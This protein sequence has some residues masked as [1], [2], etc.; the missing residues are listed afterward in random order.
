MRLKRATTLRDFRRRRRFGDE[1]ADD[2]GA[3]RR[4][5][6]RKQRRRRPQGRRPQHAR[7]KRRWSD[8][9]PLGEN[10]RIQAKDGYRGAYVEIRPGLYVVAELRTEGLEDDFGRKVRP[11]DVASEIFRVS[12]QA[13]NTFMPRR[14]TQAQP[15]PAQ[16]TTTQALPAPQAQRALP[17]PQQQVVQ[18]QY[19]PQQQYAVAPQQYAPQ[20]YAPQQYAPQQVAPQQVA[21]QQQYATAAPQ[22]QVVTSAPQAQRVQTGPQSYLPPAAARWLSMLG[23]DGGGGGR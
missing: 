2:F 16:P 14:Q 12:S 3:R 9:V 13:L 7:G 20:Q 18:Q 10:I 17:A 6:R 11:E 8:A 5:R 15:A 22:Q 19:A 23:D 21:P 4:R 1:L